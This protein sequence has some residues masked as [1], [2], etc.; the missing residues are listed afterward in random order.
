MNPCM[1]AE[2]KI[3]LEVKKKMFKKEIGYITDDIKRLL[4]FPP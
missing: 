3:I 1:Q 4:S 2:T